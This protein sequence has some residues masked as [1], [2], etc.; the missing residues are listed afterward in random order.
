MAGSGGRNRDSNAAK[1][2]RKIAKKDTSNE[3]RAIE[4]TFPSGISTSYRQHKRGIITSIDGLDVKETNGMNVS[5]IA[6]RAR[7]QGAE[8]KT[9]SAK[10]LDEHDKRYWKEQK[11]KPDWEL[12]MGVPGGNAAYR[13]TARKNRLI[14]R[15]MTR[16]SRG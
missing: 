13:K 8:V 7:R 3:I 11:E 6:E 16:K 4:I 9:Y 14:N 10:Q 2:R 1:N 5:Q 15:I 12:G